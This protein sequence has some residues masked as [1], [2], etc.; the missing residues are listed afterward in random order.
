MYNSDPTPTTGKIV[1][2][3]LVSLVIM[4]LSQIGVFKD[5]YTVSADVFKDFQQQNMKLFKNLEQDFSFLTDLGNLRIENENLKNEN[6]KLKSERLS[7]ELLIE[8]SKSI[9][10]QFTFNSEME[11]IPVRIV[12][13]SENQTEIVINKGSKE[14]IKE[15]DVLVIEKYLVGIV[16]EVS[17]SFAKGRLIISPNSKIP[18]ESQKDKL[19]GVAI[20]DGINTIVFQQIPND[21]KLALDDYVLSA[22]LGGVFPYGLIIGK[23]IKIESKDA[24]IEQKAQV[25]PEVN[26][27]NLRDIYIIREQ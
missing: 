17:D 24:D 4:I 22:G 14:G 7:Q 16:T 19:K 23:I 9:S 5:V 3:I 27:K 26:L 21:K 18:S 8:E 12:Q 13:Y 2:G 20:G 6:L 10:K 11:H 1:F 25:A 15:N